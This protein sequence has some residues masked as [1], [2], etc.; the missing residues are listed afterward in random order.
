MLRSDVATFLLGDVLSSNTL[1]Q[2]LPVSAASRLVQILN[3]VQISEGT[4]LLGF[5]DQSTE[6][7][8]V[9][10]GLCIALDSHGRHMK[11]YRP[12]HSFGELAMLD[13]ELARSSSVI[14]ITDV[15]GF[16]LTR[17]SLMMSFADM[18]EVIDKMT[19]NALE[20]AIQDATR[21]ADRPK[22][23]MLQQKLVHLQARWVKQ[24]DVDLWSSSGL[25]MVDG[26]EMTSE[27]LVGLFQ[28]LDTDA[29]GAINK[30]ELQRG[31]RLLSKTA[32]EIEAVVGSVQ[33]CAQCVMCVC[34]CM[35]GNGRRR[36]C[37]F[38]GLQN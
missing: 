7:Y 38:R 20:T 13:I 8:I 32:E 18:P 12:G 22:L 5:G 2:N 15:E 9:R 16:L 19:E 31:M 27:K 3:P 34:L 26:E 35:Y 25:G 17:K 4:L 33:V 6:A 24:G 36:A 37:R 28:Q 29:S 21:P 1:F 23:Q 30:D 11:T 10:E 14:A